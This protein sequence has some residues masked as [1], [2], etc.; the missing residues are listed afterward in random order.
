MESPIG[1]HFYIW[2]KGLFL[3]LCLQESEYCQIWVR[4]G[5]GWKMNFKTKFGLYEWLV[6]PFRLTNAPNIFMRLMNHILRSLIGKCVVVYFKDILIYSTCLDDHLLYK[7]VFFVPMKLYFSIFFVGSHGVKVDEEKVKAKQDWPIPSVGF[8]WEESQERAFQVL[9]ERLIQSPILALSKFSKSFELECDAFN[10]KQGKINVVANALSR[11]H[12]LIAML[13]TKMLGLDCIKELY[14]KDID[15]IEHFAMC[16]H[17]TYRHYGF[18]FKGKRLC[19]LMSSIQQLLVKEAQ[20]GGLTGHFRGLKTSEKLN[21]HFYWPH[22]R[23]YVHNVCERCLT[24]KLAK[25]KVSLH[26]L[27]T[28]FLI[29]TIP[30]IDIPMEFV[31]GLEKVEILFLWWLIDS[32]KWLILFLVIRVAMSLWSRLGTKILFSIICHP[33]MDGQTKVVNR[34]LGQLL[35]CFVKKNLRD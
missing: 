11:R 28:P 13:E 30:W 5:D 8:K 21:E 20:E 35:R 7:N 29:P 16:F 14:D 17:S 3:N 19:V 24:C 34:T 33:Q 31:L 10:H 18:L 27:Y 1:S 15:F 4:K 6:I 22:M 2:G 23:K 25:S 32:L 12:S 9:K 26:G